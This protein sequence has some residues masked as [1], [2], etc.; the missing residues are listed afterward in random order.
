MAKPDQNCRGV[1]EGQ[2][3][4]ESCFYGAAI[5]AFEQPR[6]GVAQAPSCLPAF[7]DRKRNQPGLQAVPWISNVRCEI[8]CLIENASSRFPRRRRPITSAGAAQIAGRWRESII[9]PREPLP[10]SLASSL[11][12]VM[13]VMPLWRLVWPGLGGC[14]DKSTVAS[15]SC[16]R[17][18]E[19]DR[20]F[21]R[22]LVLA[23]P[24]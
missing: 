11:H 4:R 10:V 19:L 1:E 17:C 3:P 21:D 18:V 16:G 2:A 24:R 23:L 5:G 13:Q 9:R 20:E 12:Y 22:V 15:V 6:Q 7:A 14:R 8:S